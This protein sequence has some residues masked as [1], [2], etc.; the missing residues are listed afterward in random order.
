MNCIGYKQL[1]L[2]LLFSGDAENAKLAFEKSMTYTYILPDGESLIAIVMYE[3]GLAL[4]SLGY[5]SEAIQK[6]EESK[7][8]AE[9][10]K[11]SELFAE[12]G[13]GIVYQSIG[14]PHEAEKKF[15]LVES[16]SNSISDDFRANNLYYLCE[17][18]YL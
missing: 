3:Y 8:R 16:Y 11:I 2:S 10:D 17:Q 18:I 13:L 15:L 7:E 9:G 14:L 1:G 4:H 5:Y 12:H 6:F